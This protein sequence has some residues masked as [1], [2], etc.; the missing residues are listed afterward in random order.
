V[1]LNQTGTVK[2]LGFIAA[3]IFLM[4]IL[5]LSLELRELGDLSGTGIGTGFNVT[6]RAGPTKPAFIVDI[7]RNGDWY[8][9]EVMNCREDGQD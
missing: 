9:L 3:H 1:F 7:V 2:S 8:E 6:V 5:P 4:R